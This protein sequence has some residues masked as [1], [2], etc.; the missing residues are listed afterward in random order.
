MDF[1]LSI[2]L[3]WDY[4]RV[5]VGKAWELSVVQ[6]CLDFALIVLNL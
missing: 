3:T 5:Y 2:I 1:G 6:M 4:N